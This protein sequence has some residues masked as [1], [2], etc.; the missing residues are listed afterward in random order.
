[1]LVAFIA[2]CGTALRTVFASELL[3]V[4]SHW[5]YIVTDISIVTEMAKIQKLKVTINLTVKRNLSHGL[6]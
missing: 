4:M 5:V 6:S 3:S 2:V 1:L